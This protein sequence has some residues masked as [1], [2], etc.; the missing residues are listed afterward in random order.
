MEDIAVGK[1]MLEELLLSRK[2]TV[3]FWLMLL[4]LEEEGLAGSVSSVGEV[5][6]QELELRVL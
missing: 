2:G 6:T 5:F 4:K 3:L 1:Q